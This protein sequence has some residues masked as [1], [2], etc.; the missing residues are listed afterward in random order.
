MAD[1]GGRGGL[2]GERE[3]RGGT[4]VLKVEG[5]KFAIVASKK[6]FL[7]PYHFWGMWGVQENKLALYTAK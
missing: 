5:T 4:T 7:A 6:I 2:H 1:R 3:P